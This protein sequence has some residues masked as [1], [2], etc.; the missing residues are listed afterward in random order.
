M[1]RLSVAVAAASAIVVGGLGVSA[2][3][4]RAQEKQVAIGFVPMV[5]LDLIAGNTSAVHA[6]L[7][8][9]VPV[10]NYFALG[11]T[12]GAGLSSS[13]FSGRLDY[14]ARFSL[15]PYHYAAWEPYFGLG[16]TTRYDSGGPNTRTYLLGFA[17]VEGPKAGSIA[18]GFEI[19]VG[20]GV[21]FG[22]TLRFA[23]P[24]TAKAQ[25]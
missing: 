19:G 22:V 3:A 5:R 4:A 12:A 14:F 10:S 21:R 6:G 9:R 20:G 24:D 1:R 18:P 15:D 25:R 2:R 7:G 17:G 16:G 23:G 8:L 13:G 11:G